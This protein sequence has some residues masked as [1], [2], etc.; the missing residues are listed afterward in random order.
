MANAINLTINTTAKSNET[1]YE[2]KTLEQALSS[3]FV[4]IPCLLLT[5]LLILIMF[6][7]LTV[8]RTVHLTQKLHYSAF[9]FVFSLAL[10][11][12]MVGFLVPLSVV[13]IV[14]QHMKSK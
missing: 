6:G 14:A 5:L 8:M 1:P 4:L 7:N 2:E 10:A 11:D 13:H 12:F 3:P 9:Y